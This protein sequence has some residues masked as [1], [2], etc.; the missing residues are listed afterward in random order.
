M[1]RFMEKCKEMSLIEI[2]NLAGGRWCMGRIT[3]QGGEGGSKIKLGGRT[4]EYEKGMGRCVN[5]YSLPCPLLFC[6]DPEMPITRK[7]CRESNWL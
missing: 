7:G 3:W 2:L 4:K 1:F 5:F 6:G